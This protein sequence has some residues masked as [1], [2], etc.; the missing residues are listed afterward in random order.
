M[1]REHW[2]FFVLKKKKSIIIIHRS[3]N[4]EKFLFDI[5]SHSMNCK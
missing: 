1:A 5:K 3:N 2:V 4:V